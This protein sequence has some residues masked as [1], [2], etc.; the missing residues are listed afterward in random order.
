MNTSRLSYY[1]VCLIFEILDLFVLS[2][3]R[4][5]FFFL[6]FSYKL[7]THSAYLKVLSEFSILDLLHDKVAIIIAYDLPIKASFKT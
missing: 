1:G 4:S 3:I 2:N 7:I 6:S 5:S